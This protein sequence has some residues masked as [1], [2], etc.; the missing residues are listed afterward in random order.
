VKGFKFKFIFFILRSLFYRFRYGARFRV[1]WRFGIEKDVVLH[2]DKGSSFSVGRNVYVTR[3]TN[4]EGYDDSVISIGDDVFVNKN[5]TIV[6]RYSVSI[7]SHC[8]LGPNICIYDHNHEYKKKTALRKQGYYGEPIVIGKNVWIGAGCF[9][10]SGVKIGDN[11]VI[12]A[13]TIVIKDIPSNTLLKNKLSY[14]FLDI[15]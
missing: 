2:L 12:A 9:I 8:Q 3:L 14:D 6:S 5:V 7:G 13:N 11:C 10:G 4:I 15:V 1:S